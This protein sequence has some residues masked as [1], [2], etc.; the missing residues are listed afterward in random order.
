M[1][2]AIIALEEDRERERITYGETEAS[3]SALRLPARWEKSFPTFFFAKEQDKKN[4]EE[5][6]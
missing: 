4:I 3:S 1:P 5:K 2:R 6:I